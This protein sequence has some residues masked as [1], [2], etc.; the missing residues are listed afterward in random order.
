MSPEVKDI[1]QTIEKF[2]ANRKFGSIFAETR[3][4][5][6]L[7]GVAGSALVVTLGLLFV[8]SLQTFAFIAGLVFLLALVALILVQA[9]TLVAA[10]HKP[11]KGYAEAAERRLKERLAYI[12]QLSVFSSESLE[13]TRKAIENDTGRMQARLGLLVGAVEK[14]GFIPAGIALYYAATKA[15]LDGTSFPASLLMAFVFGL[16]SGS[17]LGHRLLESLRFNINCL[18]EAQEA[19]LRRE[20]LHQKNNFS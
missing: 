6:A 13:A 5:K 16:Y 11:L 17:Y 2:S 10:F 18:E 12:A 15:Q 7:L 19:S 4:E 20:A 3:L 9:T 14:A 8:Q 1:L